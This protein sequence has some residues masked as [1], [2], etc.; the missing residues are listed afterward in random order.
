MLV[1][2]LVTVVSCLA[3]GHFS[4]QHTNKHTHTRRE[5]THGFFSHLIVINFK[6]REQQR[7]LFNSLPRRSNS[8][9]ECSWQR[10]ERN[11]SARVVV[12]CNHQLL[13]F[14][15]CPPC[16]IYEFA[17]D[18]RWCIRLTAIYRCAS[19]MYR[20]AVFWQRIWAN[21]SVKYVCNLFILC[22]K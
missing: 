17:G 16:A 9:R 4:T 19:I 10:A 22:L 15:F 5:H 14:S 1:F 2:Q 12:L 7:F 20:I 8:I 21:Q 18:G 13:P 11:A 3:F 6:L